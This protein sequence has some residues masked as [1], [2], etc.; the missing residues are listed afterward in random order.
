MLVHR[1]LFS[2]AACL[3]AAAVLADQPD[4]ATNYKSDAT[5]SETSVMTALTPKAAIE[6]LPYKLAAAGAAMEWAEP[7]KGLLKAGPLAVKAEASGGVTRVTFRTSPAADKET[8]CRYAT[9]LGNAPAAAAAPV[10][11][12]PALI[13]KMKDD[14]L[15]KHQI[16]QPNVRNGLNNAM[17]RSVED[18]LEFSINA[19]KELP[20]DKREYK[21]TML[22]PRNAC[23]IA[24]EDLDDSALGL[25]GQ[26]PPVR[27]KPVRADATLT[28]VTNGGA[29]NGGA[30]K[31]ADAVITHIESTK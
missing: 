22:L 3:I 4:C 28:Y 21:V 12:D 1:I 17:F 18:F 31:L 29:L 20:N 19:M 24:A 13:E 25:N 8:L 2:T 5:S 10:A 11:Q 30:W 6:A 23:A 26:L 14:L 27:T 15:K 16:V 9:L 7:A